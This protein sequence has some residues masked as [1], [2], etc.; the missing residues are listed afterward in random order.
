MIR[1]LALATLAVLGALSLAACGDSAQAQ[2]STG[3]PRI[4]ILSSTSVYANIAGDIGGDLVESASII[5]SPAQDPHS[6]EAMESDKL[7]IETS[8]K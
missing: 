2:Q 8:V 5:D 1:R 3:K 4:Q 6:H 7:A